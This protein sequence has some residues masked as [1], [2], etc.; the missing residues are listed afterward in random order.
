MEI[1][2]RSVGIYQ[3]SIK[4]R[5][6]LHAHHQYNSVTFRI[7]TATCLPISYTYLISKTPLSCNHYYCLA[8]FCQVSW[9][10]NAFPLW[11]LIWIYFFKM[12][13][14]VLIVNGDMVYI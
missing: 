13:V 10:Y 3:I 14:L 8:L 2:F 1:G 11:S 5:A 12:Q 9:S 7:E 6:D 4:R